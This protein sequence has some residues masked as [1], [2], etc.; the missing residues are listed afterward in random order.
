LGSNWIFPANSTGTTRLQRIATGNHRNLAQCLAAGSASFFRAGSQLLY[1][2]SGALIFVCILHLLKFYRKKD[3]SMNL[4]KKIGDP[5]A[6]KLKT[7][8]CH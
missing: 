2:I 8:L 5:I 6:L 7:S 1:A 4:S 3:F